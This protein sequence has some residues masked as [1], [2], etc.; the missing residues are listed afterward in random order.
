MKLS[1]YESSQEIHREQIEIIE[2]LQANYLEYRLMVENLF[3]AEARALE[4]KLTAQQ[5]KYETEIKYILRMKD[6]Q[7]H[8]MITSKDAKIMMLIEGTDFSRILMKHQMELEGLKKSHEREI[9]SVRESA[10][11]ENKKMVI[12]LKRDLIARQT[13]IDKYH[14]QILTWEKKLEQTLGQLTRTERYVG[15][16]C[17]LIAGSLI[18][19]SLSLF[20]HPLSSLPPSLA[21]LLKKQK[22]LHAMKEESS[23]KHAKEVQ[24][25]LNKAYTQIESLIQ[26]KENLRHR[27]LRLRLQIEGTADDSVPSIIKRLTKETKRLATDLSMVSFNY[28][29]RSDA[30][31]QAEKR[32][33]RLDK[34]VGELERELAHRTKEYKALVQTYESYLNGRLRS[35]VT[36]TT[37]RASMY[38]PSVTSL[39]ETLSQPFLEALYAAR[40]KN[41]GGNMKE[42][43]MRAT[44]IAAGNKPME[45]T[46]VGLRIGPP[47]PQQP[48]DEKE[49]HARHD[50][51]TSQQLIEDASRTKRRSVVFD[52]TTAAAIQADLESSTLTPGQPRSANVSARGSRAPS[53]MGDSL[54]PTLPS[55]SHLSKRNSPMLAPP[56]AGTQADGLHGRHVSLNTFPGGHRR[57]RSE[58]SVAADGLDIPQQAL[59]SGELTPQEQ[60]K[61]YQQ[62]LQQAQQYL[63][64]QRA[65]SAAAASQQHPDDVVLSGA[66]ALSASRAS[67]LHSLI[68][69]SGYS[70]PPAV[71]PGKEARSMREVQEREGKERRKEEYAQQAAAAAATTAAAAAVTLDDD[72]LDS[73]G[74]KRK[75]KASRVLAYKP[76]KSLIDIE[77]AAEFVDLHAI[78][79]LERGFSLLSRFKATSAAFENDAR[80]RLAREGREEQERMGGAGGIGGFRR[81][82]SH[83]TFQP[84]ATYPDHAHP[85]DGATFDRHTLLEQTGRVGADALVDVTEK[86]MRVYG[87]T[88]TTTSKDNGA[89]VSFNLN[90]PAEDVLEERER[91]DAGA[92]GDDDTAPPASTQRISVTNFPPSSSN[93]GDLSFKPAAL[94][95]NLLAYTDPAAQLVAMQTVG[96]ESAGEEASRLYQPA[97]ASVV[98][99]WSSAA[100]SLHSGPQAAPPAN[101]HLPAFARTQV[102][103]QHSTQPQQETKQALSRT[104]GPSFQPKPPPS[105]RV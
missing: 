76:P 6:H 45:Q 44:Q 62:H 86:A 39:L 50:S 85:Q 60:E 83:S 49:S 78:K 30:H 104:M 99:W 33:A 93:G 55:A 15:S 41:G 90:D 63:L 37:G 105:K 54:N 36:A 4:E 51:S 27:I 20:A 97:S 7:F 98:P 16:H 42:T 3:Y 34:Q 11:L 72:D 74:R 32:N 77:N 10:S 96:G 71:M 23:E 47:Q 100:G 8:T 103:L 65:P 89:S 40:G 75:K 73:N 24:L 69:H 25:Q 28:K 84:S 57:F 35:G 22:K 2:N 26:V 64:S 67:R 87:G 94:S 88:N 31:D 58:H 91:K 70:A 92:A 12:D 52:Q 56:S 17:S 43:L 61:E 95:L 59:Q 13:E 1:H 9:D 19:P 82:D 101:V 79:S 18:F 66:D 102:S 48:E 53:V 21:A 68:K 14:T 5:H 46:M 29:T 38:D 80:G 81:S